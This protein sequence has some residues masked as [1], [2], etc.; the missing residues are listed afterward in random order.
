[1]TPSGPRVVFPLE[2]IVNKDNIK[3]DVKSTAELEKV[4]LKHI[5]DKFK[6][7]TGRIRGTS[8]VPSEI[9]LDVLQNSIRTILKGEVKDYLCSDCIKQGEYDSDR[10]KLE[11][12]INTKFKEAMNTLTRE[13]AALKISSIK[14]EK[15]A[16][17]KARIRSQTQ[18]Q[19]EVGVE[20]ITNKYL[21]NGGNFSQTSEEYTLNNYLSDTSEQNNKYINLYLK[22]Y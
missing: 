16:A 19:P 22:K 3:E 12:L 4:L 17:Q 21:M 15:L 2:R 9:P 10:K 1:M 14:R 7:I 5:E 8:S 13:L 11:Q 18:P 6:E 20:A